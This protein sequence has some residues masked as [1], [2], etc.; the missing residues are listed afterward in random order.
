MLAENHSN[1]VL[2]IHSSYF[3]WNFVMWFEMCHNNIYQIPFGSGHFSPFW[4]HPTT[5]IYKVLE[6]IHNVSLENLQ[7][8]CDYQLIS[9]F[10]K[11]KSIM[12]YWRILCKGPHL[13]F[14]CNIWDIVLYVNWIIKKIN[15][16]FLPI[17]SETC[18]RMLHDIKAALLQLIINVPSK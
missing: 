13:H 11:L 7:P 1:R 3:F 9:R 5:F 14:Y 4:K 16:W 10:I 17:S 2:E 8:T 12:D 6:I 15:L 18:F